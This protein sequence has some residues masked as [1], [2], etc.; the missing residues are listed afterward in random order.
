MRWLDLGSSRLK[1]GI[2]AI[3]NKFNS[4]I[5]IQNSETVR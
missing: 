5:Q 4:K 2:V 3:L 1:T